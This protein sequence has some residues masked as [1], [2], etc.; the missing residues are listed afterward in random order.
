MSIAFF[1]IA[2]AIVGN[3]AANTRT[4]ADVQRLIDASIGGRAVLP[5]GDYEVG[6]TIWIPS[7]THLV[8][9]GCRLRMK[10]GVL[11]QMFKNRPASP[12]ASDATTSSSRT[13]PDRKLVETIDAVSI[14]QFENCTEVK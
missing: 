10:D 1:V 8:L 14:P 4:H 2:G 6:E 13:Y 12:C 3:A 7:H 9:E 5:P 11:A